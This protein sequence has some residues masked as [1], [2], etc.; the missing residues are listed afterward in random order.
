MQNLRAAKYV[1][2]NKPR[3]KRARENLGVY[4]SSQIVQSVSC[5]VVT[6]LTASW[7]VVES[8]RYAVTCMMWCVAVP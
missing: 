3:Y 1:F 6:G 2:T 4:S 7:F 5:I 8:S